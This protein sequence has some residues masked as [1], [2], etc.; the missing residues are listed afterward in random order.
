MSRIDWTLL[1]LFLA[2]FLLF[3]VGSNLPL[4][5]GTAANPTDVAI[6][7]YSG[8]YLAIGSVAAYLVLYVYNEIKKKPTAQKP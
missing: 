2:G 4:W 3:L 1:G 8:V 6:I 7:G 5:Y